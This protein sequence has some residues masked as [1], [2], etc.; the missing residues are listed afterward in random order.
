M[1]NNNNNAPN[2][3]SSP[4]SS[5]HRDSTARRRRSNRFRLGR[6]MFGRGGNTNNG[7]RD[8]GR[9]G[10]DNFHD[11]LNRDGGGGGSGGGDNSSSSNRNLNLQDQVQVETISSDDHDDGNDDRAMISAVGDHPNDRVKEDGDEEE[12]DVF[13]DAVV[14]T[15]DFMGMIAIVD[16]NS[17]STIVN[18]NNSNNIVNRGATQTRRLVQHQQT[19]QNESRAQREREQRRQEGEER[20]SRNRH[21]QHREQ[22]RRRHIEGF[23]FD[24]F[25]D[26]FMDDFLTTNLDARR[27]RVRF[28]IPNRPD[29]GEGQNNPPLRHFGA[30]RLAAAQAEDVEAT[31]GLAA[32]QADV[33]VATTRATAGAAVAAPRPA[34]SLVVARP[35]GGPTV[36]AGHDRNNTAVIEV[37]PPAA[38]RGPQPRAAFEEPRNRFR[39]RVAARRALLDRHARRRGIDDDI[40][41]DDAMMDFF[42]DMEMMEEMEMRDRAAL[43]GILAHDDADGAGRGDNPRPLWRRRVGAP[44]GDGDVRNHMRRRLDAVRRPRAR[45]NA[46]QIVSSY[47]FD[48]IREDRTCCSVLS[49]WSPSSQSCAA[50]VQHCNDHPE[51]AVYVSPQGRP[52]IHEACLRGACRHVIQA[53]INANPSSVF[54]RDNQGNT[55]LHLLFVDFSSALSG[56]HSSIYGRPKDMDQVVGDLLAVPHVRVNDA[57]NNDNRAN[58]DNARVGLGHDLASSSN[59]QGDTPLHMACMAPEA[60]IDPNTIVQLLTANPAVANRFDNKNQTPLSL[61][62][63]RRNASIAVARLLLEEAN[64]A[65]TN[66]NVRRITANEAFRLAL[67]NRNIPDDPI[68]DVAGP[69]EMP[70]SLSRLDGDDGFAPIHFAAASNNVDL[71]RFLLERYPESGLVRTSKQQSALHLVCRQQ[72]LN[73]HFLAGSNEASH[74]AGGN[75]VL[76]AVDLLLAADPDAALQ[77]DTQSYTPLHLICKQGG[78]GTSRRGA[79][80]TNVVASSVQLV[81]RLLEIQPRAAN[82]ADG[83]SY[84]P[85]HHAC[86]VGAPVEI[87]KVLLDANSPSARAETRKHDTALSLACTCNKSVDT[88]KLLIKANPH[89]LKQKNDYGF[90]PLHCICRAYQPR[91]A[92]VEALLEANPT[93]VYV[94]TNAGETATHLASSNSTAFVGILQLLINT[95]KKTKQPPMLKIPPMAPDGDMNHAHLKNR[96]GNT[97]LHDACFRGSP[98]EH[99]ETLAMANPQWV[100]VHNNGGLSP[101]QILCKNGRIDERIITTFANIGGAEIFSVVD[102]NQNTPLHSAMREDTNVTALRALVRALPHALHSKTL[103]GDS[104]LHLA[105]FRRAS[106][107]IV[108]EVAMSASSNLASPM[109]E[110]N[111]AGQ[112]PIG[113]AIEEFNTVCRPG[114]FGTCCVSFDYNREQNR[115]FQVLATLV[116][117]LYYGPARCQNQDLKDLSLLHACISL[118]RRGVRLHPTFIKRSIHMYPGEVKQC[119]DDG[120]YPLTIEA[121]IPVEKMTLLDGPQGGCCLGQCN[122]RDGILRILLEIHPDACRICNKDGYFALSLMIVNGRKWGQTIARALR[123]FPPALHMHEGLNGKILPFLFE[124]ASMECGID[125]VFSLLSSRPDLL[126]EEATDKLAMG[127]I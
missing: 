78:F 70:R 96:I 53:L 123:A 114:S 104:P 82:L 79:N 23:G 14:D 126:F 60:L 81:K 13:H 119:D 29:G 109:L 61:H 115:V 87:I 21:Y 6:M 59:R 52:A 111:L 76:A 73:N 2:S 40:D 106:F 83:E 42:E 88:V 67:Q 74:L 19:R 45:D 35:V 18:N 49:G 113:I 95:Q 65:S 15:E 120:N 36:D 38:V 107:H 31:R 122:R 68:E 127:T 103:Y 51:E 55:A 12:D 5:A 46:E 41:R 32:V 22:L 50:V 20:R 62:C 10:D 27:A 7:F 93:C 58:R 85:L 24:E 77:Q 66:N 33:V 8:R 102:E 17:T 118:H 56:V 25:D 44:N 16:H 75:D 110:P 57:R 94:E 30:E 48:L 64:H 97:P 11:G 105:I 71:L 4:S 84:L 101:L 99:F 34:E 80:D 47:L 121:G 98:F 92:I 9:E 125:V 91:M 69:N 100:A 124:K 3:S 43:R 86:E 63:K 90:V 39:G 37:G 1:S 112:T 89:A 117:I 26:D 108:R 72:Q 28:G 54:E 116:K